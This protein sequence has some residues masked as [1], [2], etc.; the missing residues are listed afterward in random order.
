MNDA[1][2]VPEG[3]EGAKFPDVDGRVGVSLTVNGA[4]REFR[5]H[6]MGTLLDA[7]R[8]ELDLHGA[9]NGCGVGMCGACTVLRD[10]RAVSGCLTF[11][12]LCDGAD[13]RTVEGLEGSDGELSKVQQAFLS[14]R[15]FQCSYCTSGFILALEAHLATEADPTEE[16]IRE[17]FSGHI[18]RCG[19]YSR[20]MAAAREA[21]G[22]G[23]SPRAEQS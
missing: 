1:Q 13:V 15:A 14:H 6:V 16:S 10:G 8:D 21:A 3:S 17:A 19:S 18:C 11:A 12:S 22:L 2:G 23:R 7:L 9:R 4:P 5:V 20:I